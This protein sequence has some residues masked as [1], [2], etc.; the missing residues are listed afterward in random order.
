[1]F[2]VRDP[3]LSFEEGGERF[4]PELALTRERYIERLAQ[5]RERIREDI[6]GHTLSLA[7]SILTPLRLVL[8]GCKTLWS[9]LFWDNRAQLLYDAESR[10]VHQNMT[11]KGAKGR[12]LWQRTVG[13]Q[14]FFGGAITAH[15]I[16]WPSPEA[17]RVLLRN[18]GELYMFGFYT[19]GGP[20]ER[21][22]VFLSATPPLLHTGYTSMGIGVVSVKGNAVEDAGFTVRDMQLLQVRI[23]PA[24]FTLF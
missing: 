18:P 1:M 16:R 5:E 14:V 22:K 6:G 2:V 8:D 12:M 13:N 3:S 9:S 4:T 21:V 24:R 20:T 15:N 19:V 10:L 23:V 7:A 17:E 11:V